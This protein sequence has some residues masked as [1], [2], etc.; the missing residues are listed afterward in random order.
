[1]T[2]P[3]HLA[4]NIPGVWGQRPQRPGPSTDRP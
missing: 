3:S 2:A 1:M 4:K